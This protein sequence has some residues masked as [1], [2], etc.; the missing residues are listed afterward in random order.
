MHWCSSAHIIALISLVLCYFC[1]PV[2]GAM[3]KTQR[4]ARMLSETV[5]RFRDLFVCLFVCFSFPPWPRSDC[6][7]NLRFDFSVRLSTSS[8][9]HN[10]LN[11]RGHD[12][13]SRLFV[14]S[15][16]LCENFWPGSSRELAERCS[17]SRGGIFYFFIEWL[18][19]TRVI[20]GLLSLTMG[21]CWC[22]APPSEFRKTVD[23][24]A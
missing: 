13:R 7:P 4:H 9:R 23:R 21:L 2:Y 14:S 18:G 17:T 15:S 8:K 1:L 24:L 20:H 16:H 19:V 5:V 12:F 3:L 6:Y 11:R 22:S 10:C